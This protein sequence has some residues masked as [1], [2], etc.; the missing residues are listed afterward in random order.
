M[1][2]FVVEPHPIYRRGAV[3]CLSA[4]PEIL[5]V[6]EAESVL[7]A[8]RNPALLCSDVLLLDRDVADA[9]RLHAQMPGR[10]GPRVV[11]WAWTWT[12][13]SVQVALRQGASALLLKRGLVPA[14]LYNAV[15]AAGHGVTVSSEIHELLVEGP[16]RAITVAPRA[17]DHR[18]SLSSREQLVLRHLA[19]GLGTR[20]VAHD[21]NW[22]ERTVKSVVHDAITKLGARNRSQ[23][24]AIAIRSGLV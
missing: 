17:A 13:Q 7:S 5:G 10:H 1:H 21:L 12:A 20:E 3:A 9:H 8:E 15:L 6:A 11:L 16:A 24:V 23:A 19:D 22:S 18:G 14:S 2:V 4:T